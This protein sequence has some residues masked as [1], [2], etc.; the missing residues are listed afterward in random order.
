M[1]KTTKEKAKIYS[2]DEFDLEMSGGKKHYTT[3]SPAFKENNVAVSIISS[4]EYCPFAGILVQSIISNSSN[5]YNYD[6][7]VLTN[8]MKYRN[9]ARIEEMQKG[10]SNV[11]VRVLDISKMIEGF[12]FYTWAHFTSNTYYRLL[13]PDVFCNYEKVIY[14]D[15]DIIVNHDI[16]E[17]FNIDI[18]GYYLGCAYDTHVVSYCTRKPSLEQREYNIETLG[19]KKPEEYFQAGVSLY[20][21]KEIRRDFEEGYL[22]KQGTKHKLRWLDQDLIN[23]LFQGH[24]KRLPN[25]WNVMISNIP[26]NL[27]EYHLPKKLR[28]EYYEARKDPYIIHYV[29]RSMPCYTRDPDL[30]EYFWKYAKQ[31]VFYEILLQKMSIDYSEKLTYSIVYEAQMGRMKLRPSLIRKIK[32][33]I[34]CFFPIGT[35][36]RSVFDNICLFIKGQKM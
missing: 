34:L 31:T 36:R 3:L 22:F 18:T 5:S 14:L 30:Y 33:L 25:K 24:I 21:V 12:K 2:L 7:V 17:L 11:S 6:I 20:N 16:S 10:H 15:S 27:D 26:D 32:N 13:T 1:K 29:G 19:L 35:R 28:Q 4:D 8:D 9:M 23:M